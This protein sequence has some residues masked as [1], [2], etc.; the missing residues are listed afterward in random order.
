MLDLLY[1]GLTSLHSKFST[2]LNEKEIESFMNFTGKSVTE[3]YFTQ[4]FHN[5]L[6]FADILKRIGSERSLL[7]VTVQN[8]PQRKRYE[9]TMRY[10]KLEI[11]KCHG[12]F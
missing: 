5:F 1:F 4:Q 10:L 9:S 11:M 2:I 7:S 12:V 8:N 6:F 3:V